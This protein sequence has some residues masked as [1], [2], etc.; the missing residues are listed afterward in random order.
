MKIAGQAAHG[1]IGQRDMNHFAAG[2]GRR[3]RRMSRRIRFHQRAVEIGHIEP[4]DDIGI[5]DEILV[6][7]GE[8]EHVGVGKIEPGAEIDHGNR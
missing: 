3:H 6:L 8:I 1:E 7:A 4:H 2:L 5:G